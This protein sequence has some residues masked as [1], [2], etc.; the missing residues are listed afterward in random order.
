MPGWTGPSPTLVLVNPEGG[1]VTQATA[2]V[3]VAPDVV[4]VQFGCEAVASTLSAALAAN[5]AAGQALVAAARAWGVADASI[6]TERTQVHPRYDRDGTAP[7]AFA[8]SSGYRVRVAAVERAGELVELLATAGGEAF[9]L[10]GV[11]FSVADPTDARRRARRQAVE[12]ALV[13][14][15]ELAAAAG[16]RMG[17]VDSIVEIE[18]TGPAGWSGGGPLGSL[19]AAAASAPIEGGAEAVSVTVQLKVRLASPTTG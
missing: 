11:G 4:T 8:A 3:E 1:I 13:Q 18:G 15:A 9:R 7:S 5:A 6:R 14:A 19:R 17:E 2:T 10:H 16:V 12:S